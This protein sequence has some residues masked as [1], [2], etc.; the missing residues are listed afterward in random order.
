V[1]RHNRTYGDKPSVNTGDAD[2]PPL[3]I[4][5]ARA[6]FVN[7]C[8]CGNR[9]HADWPLCSVCQVVLEKDAKP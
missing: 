8:W 7:E 1:N 4:A 6:Q 3:G 9:K 5:K 2:E